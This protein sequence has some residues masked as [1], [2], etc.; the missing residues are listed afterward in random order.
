MYDANFCYMIKKNQFSLCIFN[1]YT[2]FAIDNLNK[3]IRLLGYEV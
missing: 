1:F 2:I 3:V